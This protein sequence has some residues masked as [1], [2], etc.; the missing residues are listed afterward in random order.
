MI[1]P[2]KNH[3]DSFGEQISLWGLPF[4]EYSGTSTKKLPENGHFV[5]GITGGAVLYSKKL[6]ETIGL[7][8]EKFFMYYEDIDLSYR[9]QLYGYKAYASEKAIV[10][11]NQGSSASKVHGLTTYNT[12]K[13]LPML[14][15]KNVPF[16]LWGEIYPR[17]F[18]VY[19]LIFGNAIVN[20]R[21]WPALKGF[22]MSVI[23]LPHS[24]VARSRI[25]KSRQVSARYI[26]NIITHDVPPEQTGLRKFRK[27]FTG[28]S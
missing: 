9:A 2:I 26:N 19:C 10:Y 21:G 5:F 1:N 23:Y 8:D 24:L 3:V 13:N 25:Q 28:K 22:L 20:G 6:L 18:L 12:F 4:S 17:F 16:A 15:I 27:I 7:F 14:F 11:H